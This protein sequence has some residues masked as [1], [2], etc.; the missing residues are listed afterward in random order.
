[1][2][3]SIRRD[4]RP[5]LPG[6]EYLADHLLD[7]Y[8]R[9]GEDHA[10]QERRETEGGDDSLGPHSDQLAADRDHGE[11]EEGQVNSLFVRAALL[12]GLPHLFG[13]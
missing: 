6:R 3:I 1:L 2:K 8:G 4:L 13:L 5:E 11:A 9:R 10:D 12:L 7:L